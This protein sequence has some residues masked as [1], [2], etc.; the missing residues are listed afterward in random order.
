MS[1]SGTLRDRI[2]AGSATAADLLPLVTCEQR[3]ERAQNCRDLA[4]AFARAGDLRQAS[5]FSKRAL[6][7]SGYAEEFLDVYLDV[8]L[9]LN[10]TD[11]VRY[12]Y[13]R[14]GMTHAQA[15]DIAAAIRNFNLAHYAHLRGGMGDRFEYDHEVLGAIEA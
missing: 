13:T 14:T 7:L 9:A 5:V 4:K 12:G 8:H 6:S 10:D 11:A 1:G 2:E 15:G 3:A